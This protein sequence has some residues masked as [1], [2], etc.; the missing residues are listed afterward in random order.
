[1]KKL[2]NPLVIIANGEFP[3]HS[4][5]LEK[6][7]NAQSI[8]ACDG[9]INNLEN[10]KIEPDV[11]IGDLDSI[12]RYNKNKYKNIIIKADNQSKNDLRKAINLCI[13][14]KINKFSIIGASGKREDHTLGN[15]FSLLE[16]RDYNIKLFTDTGVF[17]T[18]SDNK[19]IESFKGQK[20]SIFSPDKSIKI[21]SKYLKYNF[22][23]NNISTLFD[24]TL[25]ESTNSFLNLRLS[26]GSILI[27]QSYL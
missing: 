8:I 5:P 25:N 23:K 22:N 11:I 9:A 10:K 13:K 6:L 21:S 16:Y 27:Y 20:I 24:G 17:H 7:I 15:I 19:K 4:T 2:K 14:N 1:M 26:H 18:V 12:S 3:T